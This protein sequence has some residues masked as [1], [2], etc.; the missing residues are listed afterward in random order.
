MSSSPSCLPIPVA[1]TKRYAECHSWFLE[2]TEA[3]AQNFK[4]LWQRRLAH[5]PHSILLC[6]NFLFVSQRANQQRTGNT[7]SS[8]V[9]LAGECCVIIGISMIIYRVLMSMII[10]VFSVIV[11]S[12]RV[13]QINF[14]R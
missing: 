14:Q 10:Y 8:K 4:L 12:F 1:I 11:F 5:F 9:D 2:L 3:M 7:F 13:D 6:L